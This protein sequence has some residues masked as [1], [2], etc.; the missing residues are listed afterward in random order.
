[1]NYERSIEF[2]GDP[3]RAFAAA[4]N[5]L[6]P[7]NFNLVDKTLGHAAFEGGGMQA[8]WQNPLVGATRIRIEAKGERLILSAY[9]GGIRFM[10]WFLFLFPFALALLLSGI[11]AAMEVS[12]FRQMAL[13]A[14]LSVSPWMVL[15]PLMSLWLKRRTE[16]ALD[17]LLSNLAAVVDEF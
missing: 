13:I 12:P 7:N 16:R 5:I 8:S 6:M 2:H 3:V 9:L 17:T 15:S 1:M 10:A 11:F 14:F 4:S